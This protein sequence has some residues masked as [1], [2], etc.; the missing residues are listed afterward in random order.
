MR[1]FVVLLFVATN[2]ARSCANNDIAL[3]G[4][5]NVFVD[6]LPKIE[7]EK[8][9]NGEHLSREVRA[10]LQRGVCTFQLTGSHYRLQKAWHCISC[11]LVDSRGMCD[12]C[13]RTCHADHEVVC[14]GV[15]QF[16]WCVALAI[17][18]SD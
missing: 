3:S 10:A 17:I 4:T 15:S 16:F 8:T 2:G 7:E 5:R 11:K 13:R 12:V 6:E 9:E 18:P 14:D 1:A